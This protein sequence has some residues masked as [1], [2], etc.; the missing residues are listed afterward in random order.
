MENIIFDDIN[1]VIDFFRGF[2]KLGYGREGDCYKINNMSYKL[3]NSI[4]YLI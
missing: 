3:Y 2:R 1:H 4:Y